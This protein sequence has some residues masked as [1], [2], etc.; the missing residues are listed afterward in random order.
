MTLVFTLNLL[1]L[2]ILQAKKAKKN[3]TAEKRVPTKLSPFQLSTV[4]WGKSW[5]GYVSIFLSKVY[6][7][8]VTCCNMVYC[9][10]HTVNRFPGRQC[11][12]HSVLYVRHFFIYCA[13]QKHFNY[14]NILILSSWSKVVMKRNFNSIMNS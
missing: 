14:S 9:F 5:N 2:F 6:F 8:A 12:W 4:L 7:C 11:W 13:C 10:L 1:W 3:K